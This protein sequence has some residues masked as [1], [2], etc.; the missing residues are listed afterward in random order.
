MKLQRKRFAALPA[1]L[2]AAALL[3]ALTGSADAAPGHGDHRPSVAGMRILLSNDD[4]M[5]N[6]KADGG[7]GRGVYEVRRALCAAGADVVVMA[8]WQFMSGF[9]TAATGNGA[10]TVSRRTAMP[11]GFEGD[12]AQAP[13][14]GAVFGVCKGDATCGPTTPSATP[15]DTVRLALRG[16]LAAKVGWHDGPDLVLTGINSGPNVASV[17]NDSGTLGAAIAAIDNGK[18][19]I[20]LSGGFDMESFKVTPATYRAFADFLPSYVAQLK[21]RKALS[22]EYVISINHPNVVPGKL[23]GRPV[24]TEIGTETV[25]AI[26]YSAAPGGDTFAIGQ[27]DCEVPGTF[28]RPETKRHADWTELNKGNITVSA[29]TGDRT[30]RG[31]ADDRLERFVKTG[32]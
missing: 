10:L 13:S 26:R 28:C 22:D 7:D 2:G 15:V 27:G 25:V 23:P 30:L 8:P 24:W 11:A 3:L 20:A 21:D 9:G 12:C 5:Q 31:G 29:V 18:P 4:S 16:G 1:A 19:A 17:T 6:A 14:K 32:R